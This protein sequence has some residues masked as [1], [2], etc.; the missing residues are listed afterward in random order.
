[1][2]Q[3]IEGLSIPGHETYAYSASKAA[4]HHL[5]RV[6]ANQIGH[7]NITVN[8]IAAGQNIASLTVNIFG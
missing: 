6:M 5:S 2:N 3:L 4:V 8:C 1:M 7:Y